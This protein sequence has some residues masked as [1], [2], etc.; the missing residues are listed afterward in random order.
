MRVENKIQL[1][2]IFKGH[3]NET[4]QWDSNPRDWNRYTEQLQS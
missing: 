3:V 1:Y 4:T 2:S